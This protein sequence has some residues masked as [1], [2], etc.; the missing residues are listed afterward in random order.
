MSTRSEFGKRLKNH[1]WY[2]SYSDDHR[3]W[4]AGADSI[5]NLRRMH[6]SLVCPFSMDILC[7]WAHSMIVED[8]AEA[9][10]G[11]WYRQ[12]QKY[13]NMAAAKR[14]DLITRIEHDD[15][16]QWLLALGSTVEELSSFV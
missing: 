11:E 16:T 4:R 3:V 1:D 12:P 8:F 15:I 2:Y 9:P 14:E 13:K 7:K 10:A 6:A 5:V